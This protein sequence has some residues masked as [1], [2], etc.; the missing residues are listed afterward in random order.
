MIFAPVISRR[1]A[2]GLPRAT[3]A[4]MQR[5][6]QHTLQSASASDFTVTSDDKGIALELDVPGLSREQLQIRIEGRQVYLASV[7]GAPRTVRRSW[8]LAEDI[9]A[10]ASSARLENG[11]LTLRLARQAPADKSVQLAIG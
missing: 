3:D 8:E 7:E 4:A 1:T 2:F 11:V 9:D 10:S 6:M 5:F